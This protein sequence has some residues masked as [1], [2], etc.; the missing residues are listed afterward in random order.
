M[1]TKIIIAAATVATTNA[2]A[3]TKACKD[4][5]AANS[6]KSTDDILFNSEEYL[7]ALT[8]ANAA[9]PDADKKTATTSER[10]VQREADGY[11]FSSCQAKRNTVITDSTFL[12][13]LITDRFNFFFFNWE[14]PRGFTMCEKDQPASKCRFTTN[15]AATAADLSTEPNYLQTTL[16]L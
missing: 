1:N 3:S 12:K 4:I 15:E 13:Y 11:W 6:V 8:G 14:F 7:A 9:L 10:V 16:D 2:F 5:Y